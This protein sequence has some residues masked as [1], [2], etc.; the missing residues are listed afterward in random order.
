MLSPIHKLILI[1]ALILGAGFIWSAGES[2]DSYTGM[3]YPEHLAGPFTGGFGEET[4][5]SCHFDYDVN[6]GEGSFSVSGIPETVQ[7]KKTYEIEILIER[8]DLGKAGFQFSA[9]FANG[10]QAGR[11]AISEN[12]RL[13]F[14][15][16]VP[17]SLQYV[18][19]AI[20]GTEPVK[21]GMNRWQVEWESPASITDS[22]YFNIAANA[23]NGDQSE[24]GDWIY[25]KEFVAG[26][27]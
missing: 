14:T 12:N 26:I 4:C 18:Q 9:R 17:D 5:H 21:E 13:M 19:H 20:E 24:F 22:V 6:W 2:H 3:E 10:T 25:V 11:F 16:E 8:D 15:K 27:N 23:A 7:S 1:P